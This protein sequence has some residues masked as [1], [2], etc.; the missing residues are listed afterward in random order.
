MTTMQIP[1]SPIP[2]QTVSA[3]VNGQNYRVTVRSLG[4]RLY[5]SLMV[6]GERVSDT[7]AAA[8]GGKAVPWAQ[9]KANTELLWVDTQGTEA[10]RYEGLGSRWLLTF[11]E[12]E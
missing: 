9:I 6:D 1:L 10:P 4:G 5:C 7:V 8:A 2:F 3:V 12:T 11:E